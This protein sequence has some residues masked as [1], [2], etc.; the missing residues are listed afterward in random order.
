M[1]KTYF[2]VGAVLLLLVL[3]LAACQQPAQA[4][5]AE[6][7]PECPECPDVEAPECPE[8]E[9]PEC[10]ECPEA[11]EP[12]PMVAEVEEAWSASPHNDAEAEA[13][14]HWDEDD[15]AEVP[16][17]CAACHTTTGYMD[18]LGADGSEAG[19]VETPHA[20]GQTVT[21]EACHNQAAQELDMVTF[22]SG[23]EITGLGAE[24]R[25]MVC[26]QGRASKVQVDESIE[27]AGLLE[28][29]DGTSEDLGFINIHYYAAGAT[30]YGTAAKGGY[31]YEGKS[32]DFKN[33]HVEGYD[34]C[35]ACH[36][37]HTLELKVDECAACHT[38]VASAEDVR[39]IRMAGSLKDYDGDG[40]IEEGIASEIDG[41][42]DMLNTAIQAYGS[43][44][45]GSPIVYDSLAYP[46]FFIDTNEDG[47][48]GEDEAVFPNAYA[49]WTPRLLK[50]AYNFQVASKD[51]G[52]YAHGGKYI[53]Q[54]LYDSI[55]DLNEAISTPVDLSTANRID[56]GHFAG[57]EEAFRHW[58]EDGEVEGAC[59]KCHSA[60][61]LPRFLKEGVNVSEH[62]ANGL[63]CS[64]CHDDLT[65][66]TRYTVDE[67]EFPSGAVLTFGEMND[68]N[69]CINCH[70][71]RQSTVGLDARI[72]DL[73]GDAAAEGL[74]FSNPH[75]FAAGAT[76]F[77]TEAKG[78]YEFG[79]QSYDGR[80][81]H[82]QGFETCKDC[83]ESHALEVKAEACS[84]CHTNVA[85][86]EDLEAIR[87]TA[88]DFDGDGD[89]TEGIAGEIETMKEALYA[90]IQ[91]YAATTAGAAIAF[92]PGSYPYW[93]IDTNEDGEAVGE[94]AVR[95]NAYV[96][97]TPNL[98]RA[99]YNYT[100]VEKDPGAYAHNGMYM[101]QVLYD[102]LQAVGGDVGGMTRP[103]VKASE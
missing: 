31:E 18:F 91:E 76:L 9:V 59:A 84:A 62:L 11:E 61:G 66:F 40:D 20:I 2:L 47:E 94:E 35:I 58:D 41:L 77:G 43:E 97:W 60:A 8:V 30:L 5:P 78:A 15:P 33:D 68:S 74:S 82:V 29:V 26:H 10:P 57:S 52:A 92:N 1:K 39:A 16:E 65:T 24:A 48:A 17:S 85:S 53:I 21:C 102:S 73:S 87:I 7:C 13:F 28:D 72:G 70:Q 49:T 100:W 55:E 32:Y 14:V 4:P 79:G 81:L 80:N 51:P 44:V 54:L 99:A 50:A 23:S 86:A 69:L 63:V 3:V 22:P 93:F 6:P 46:Y 25:C 34:T 89:E 75:Y 88:G 71:G 96:S 36:N 64:T 27:A 101:M 83:H 67:V 37:S 45:A 90:A 12:A 98:L 42:R 103:P 38:G 56:A 95:D 19:T